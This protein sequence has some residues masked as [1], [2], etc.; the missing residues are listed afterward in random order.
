M[1][2]TAETRPKIVDLS[3]RTEEVLL[4]LL[5][6]IEDLRNRLAEEI[7]ERATETKGLKERLETETKD[8]GERLQVR[9]Y[10]KIR[11]FRK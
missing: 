6:D 8:L 5:T 10:R 2:N 4:L 9:E 1:T 11:F 3:K 7:Q